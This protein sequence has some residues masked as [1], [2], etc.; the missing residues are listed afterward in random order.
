MVRPWLD[1]SA[2]PHRMGVPHARFV[3]TSADD[4][5]VCLIAARFVI[6]DRSG[7]HPVAVLIGLSAAPRYPGAGPRPSPVSRIACFFF[8]IALI[9]RG[10]TGLHQFRQ[11]GAREQREQFHDRLMMG[12]VPYPGECG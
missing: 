9:C 6:A 1:L 8:P 4:E 2:Q 5:T 3:S 7:R 12:K 11:R 10:M